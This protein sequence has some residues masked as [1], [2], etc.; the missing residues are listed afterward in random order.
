MPSN[1]KEK[2]LSSNGG[3]LGDPVTQPRLKVR[4]SARVR[5]L[6]L[7]LPALFSLYYTALF[8]SRGARKDVKAA[9]F[10]TAWAF[11]A[12]T[13]TCYESKSPPHGK[14]AEDLFLCVASG[15]TAARTY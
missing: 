6:L 12:V 10:D 13:S 5:G 15:F 4:R 9:H 3:T 8:A 2:A 11:D 7:L 14:A 1:N